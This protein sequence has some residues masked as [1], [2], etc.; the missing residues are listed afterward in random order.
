M[1]LQI[2]LEKKLELCGYADSIAWSTLYNGIYVY[3]EMTIVEM[4]AWATKHIPSI[5][6]NDFNAKR[7]RRVYS[8]FLRFVGI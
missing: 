7:D 5:D 2:F 8:E 3:Q 6:R 4:A 1:T